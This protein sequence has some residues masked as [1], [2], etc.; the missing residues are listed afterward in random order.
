LRASLERVRQTGLADSMAVQQYDIR[1]PAEEGG[2]FEVR[3]WSPV[4][5]P[6]LDGRNQLRYIVHQVEDVTEFVHLQEHGAEQEAVTSQLRERTA[7]MEREIVARSRELQRA[8]EALRAANLAKNE[9]LSRMSH[10]L[11]TPLAAISGFSELLTL[12][13]IPEDKRPWAAT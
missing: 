6:V 11:R 2:G 10:E 7:R 13:D 1:R 3:Y 8:N 5:A 9:F 12:S 4:N